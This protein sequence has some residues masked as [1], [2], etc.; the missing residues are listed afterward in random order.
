MLGIFASVLQ[1]NE[2]RQGMAH[3]GDSFETQRLAHLVNLVNERVH[4][5]VIN[6]RRRFSFSTMPEVDEDELEMPAQVLSR[7]P[8]CSD[9]R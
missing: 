1:S 6:L 2:A 8:A 3:Y 7:R 5:D 9:F 4:G